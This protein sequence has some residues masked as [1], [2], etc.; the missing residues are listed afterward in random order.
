[1]RESLD[2]NSK[3]KFGERDDIAKFISEELSFNKEKG[4]RFL[5]MVGGDMHQLTYS[6]GGKASNVHGGFPIF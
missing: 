6:Q 5:V 3:H 2:L 1:M 4:G